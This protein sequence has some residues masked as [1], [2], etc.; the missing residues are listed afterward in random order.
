MLGK[1]KLNCKLFNKASNFEQ[2]LCVLP[3]IFE[4]LILPFNIE[5]KKLML[6]S[7]VSI[8]A[9]LFCTD[10]KFGHASLK[11][12]NNDGPNDADEIKNV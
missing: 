11:Y 3:E 9:E 2:V 7:K 10:F 8:E 6:D 4:R 5:L 1:Y 12:Q